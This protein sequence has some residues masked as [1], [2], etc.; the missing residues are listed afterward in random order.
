VTRK[1]L[2]KR[3]G[4]AFVEK[5][6]KGK[7]SLQGIGKNLHKRGELFWEEQAVPG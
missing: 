3:K 6:P 4:S 7:K 5:Y 2:T 1:K